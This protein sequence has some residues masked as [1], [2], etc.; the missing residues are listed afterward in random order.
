MASHAKSSSFTLTSPV[1][2]RC[3]LSHLVMQYFP[4][5][6][7]LTPLILLMFLHF[8]R[9]NDWTKARVTS[10]LERYFFKLNIIS[11][12]LHLHSVDREIFTSY[13]MHPL[14]SFSL[15]FNLVL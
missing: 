8:K 12:I 9:E 7:L 3:T 15:T 11:C 5:D 2:G 1:W 6:G 4:L 13:P 14:K 10:N